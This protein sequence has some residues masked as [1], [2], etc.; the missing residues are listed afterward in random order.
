MRAASRRL[1]LKL[2]LW[3]GLGLGG[4]FALLGLTGSPDGQPVLDELGMSQGF[5][6]MQAEDAEFMID[7]MDTLL[8]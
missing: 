3:V 7:L 5:E 6:A 4:V 2:H 1:W 8:D